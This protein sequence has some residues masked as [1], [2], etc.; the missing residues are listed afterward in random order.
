MRP[1]R[2][3]CSASAPRRASRVLA[4]AGIASPEKFFTT[5]S[6]SGAILA[7]QVAFPDHHPY[8]DREL[9]H[10]LERA[11]QL[12]ALLAT[13]PKDAVRLPES[14]RRQ[15]HIVDVTLAWEDTAAL[16]ALL[17]RTM[18]RRPHQGDPHA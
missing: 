5:L 14:V 10:L 9:R 7:A 15:V 1:S 18:C 2:W 16:D 11:A 6:E 8:T 17:M 13:T 12:D 3:R 4:F